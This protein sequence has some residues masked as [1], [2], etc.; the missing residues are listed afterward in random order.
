M[1]TVVQSLSA[2]HCMQ[3]ART[4][5]L[6]YMYYSRTV[7]HSCVLSL[8]YMYRTAV[9]VQYSTAVQYGCR[10]MYPRYSTVQLYGT[11]TGF[12]YEKYRTVE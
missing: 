4:V 12:T 6:P 11:F 5:L 7:P 1:H 10:Y 2:R 9:L 3:P 8:G